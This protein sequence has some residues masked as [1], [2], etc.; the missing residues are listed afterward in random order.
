MDKDNEEIIYRILS[1]EDPKNAIVVHLSVYI[2]GG[3]LLGGI[4]R[5]IKKKLTIPYS[6]LVLGVGIIIGLVH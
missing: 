5:E 1:S 4:L 6:P 3:L 2:L